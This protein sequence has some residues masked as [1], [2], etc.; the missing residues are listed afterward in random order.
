MQP[1]EKVIG[2]IITGIVLV[3][4]WYVGK[5]WWGESI[6]AS[7]FTALIAAASLILACYL[8]S[9]TMRLR[10]TH[11]KVGRLKPDDTN[12]SNL[13]QIRVKNLGPGSIKPITKVTYLRDG[14]GRHLGPASYGATE[15]YW[16]FIQTPN[17]RPS[18]AENDEAYAEVLWIRDPETDTPTP[19]IHAFDMGLKELWDERKRLKDQSGLRIKLTVS[20]EGRGKGYP[21]LVIERSYKV[22]PD[23]SHSLKYKVKRVWIQSKFWH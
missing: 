12:S 10:R 16:R 8:V 7:R 6:H 21:P 20:Y 13:F 17:T 15:V 4:G 5:E 23:R 2:F 14:R 22:K 1:A 19:T 9:V 3:G 18:L 11:L